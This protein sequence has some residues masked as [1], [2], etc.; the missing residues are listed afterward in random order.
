MLKIFLF[1][2]L[3]FGLI[4]TTLAQEEKV[5]VLHNTSK[6]LTYTLNPGD[7]IKGDRIDPN[8]GLHRF[9]GSIGEIKDEALILKNHSVIPLEQIRDLK[10]RPLKMRQVAWGTLILG[11]LV[12]FLGLIAS[13]AGFFP[14]QGKISGSGLK[15]GPS[16]MGVG[17]GMQAI[18][19][20][21]I[22]STALRQINNLQ[23]EWT[24]E[25]VTFSPPG[26]LP[27][28]MP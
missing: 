10:T 20:P 14:K 6:N 16:L 22:L 27:I 23:K 13:I 2:A 4:S 18:L 5:I 9:R 11:Y 7:F 25:V 3:F 19:F 24:Y 26:K 28:P 21:L 1:L 17:L 15:Y 12:L 8:K